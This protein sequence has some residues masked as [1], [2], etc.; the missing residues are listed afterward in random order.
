M[1]PT[2]PATRARAPVRPKPASAALVPQV[3][4]ALE[5]PGQALEPGTRADME[6]RFGHD[7]SQVRV[8]TDGR[9]ASAAKDLQSL[10][11]THGQDIVFAAGQYSPR[12]PAGMRLLAH[13]LAHTVQQRGAPRTA[14]GFTEVSRP[15]APLEREAES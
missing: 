2:A 13:E 5:S 4:P 10:A 1:K 11:F 9:A 8:H 14:Q 15:G 6:A 12:T 7:F 3:Q